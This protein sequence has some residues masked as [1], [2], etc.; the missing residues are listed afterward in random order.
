MSTR[1]LTLLRRFSIAVLPAI[2][3]AGFLIS[4]EAQD[5][6]KTQARIQKRTYDFK[7]AGK[8]M[9]YTLFVPTSYDKDKKSPLIIAL[10]G[11]GSNP[12]QIIRYK[13]LTDLAEKHGYIV[14]CPMGYNP[15]GW[16]GQPVPKKL[17]GKDDPENLSELSEKDVMNVLGIVKKE[18]NVDPDRIYLMGHSMG[19]GGTFHLAFKHPDIWAALGPIAPAIFRKPTDVEKIKHIPIVMVQGDK[20]NL[21]KVEGPRR[22]AE[23]MKKAGMTYE[24]IEVAGGDHVSIA[25]DKMPDIFAFFDKHKRKAKEGK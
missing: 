15:R 1:S 16:Y 5:A 18:F 22:W 23:E 21:V 12:N 24:Y 11:L 20:D 14:A 19:G 7:D 10:H 6:G 25:F 17:A 13:G 9:E 4:C 3:A 2:L 8:E